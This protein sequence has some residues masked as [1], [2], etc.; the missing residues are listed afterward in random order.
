MDLLTKS[1]VMPELNPILAIPARNEEDRLPSL[2]ASLAAQ[3]WQ[4]YHNRPLS[5]VM[6]LNNCTDGSRYAV[7]RAMEQYKTLAI[8]LIEEH[9]EADKAHV[10][11]ARRLAMETALASVS[12]PALTAI[13]TTDADSTPRGDWVSANVRHLSEGID[14]VCGWVWLDKEEYEQLSRHFTSRTQSDQD[15]HQA[16]DR[17]A[18]LL[19]PLPHDPWP[20]HSDRCGASLALKGNV[21]QAI[22]GLP[23]LPCGEDYALVDRVRDAGYLIRHPMDVVVETSARLVGRAPGGM[24]ESLRDCLNDATED[25]PFLVEHPKRTW[26]RLKMHHMVAENDDSEFIPAHEAMALLNQMIAEAE[27]A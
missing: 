18:S 9:F 25:R 11:S 27:A 2:F 24:A 3:D 16:V 8:T 23:A 4:R 22:G 15:Y 5:V 7:K 12:D 10:G 17:L 20:R 13:L 21:Y 1:D 19:N 14:L 6:V 26:Q